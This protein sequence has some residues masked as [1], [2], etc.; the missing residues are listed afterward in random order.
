MKRLVSIAAFSVAVGGCAQICGTAM[1]TAG[2]TVGDAI[3]KK[4]GEHIVR[5]WNPMLVQWTNAYLFAVAF[6]S[7]G[8]EISEVGY[9]PGDW[10]KWQLEQKSGSETSAGNDWIERAFLY[11][12]K[13]K[14][15]VW[16]VKFFDA[17]DNST[18][19]LEAKFTPDRSKLLRLRGKYPNDTEAKEMP[20]EDQTYYIPPRKLT[21]ESLKGAT[22]GSE[23]V[24]VPAGTFTAQHVKFGNPGGTTQEWWLVSTGVPGGNVMYKESAP[25]QADANA[26]EG[27]AGMDPD[28]YSFKLHSHGSGAVSELGMKD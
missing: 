23:S 27:G 11:A 16:R 10:T 12:D 6:H 17:D 5:T 15:Q 13:D 9:K 22:V 25:K 4:V 7:G 19:T 2:Q 8:Y 14:N 1:D 3:G 20:V 21:K 18:I 24:T 28:N 26:P